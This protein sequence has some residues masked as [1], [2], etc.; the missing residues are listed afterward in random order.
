MMH[1]K[2]EQPATVLHLLLVVLLAAALYAVLH[3]VGISASITLPLVAVFA[4]VTT[5][6]ILCLS[7]LHGLAEHKKR[8]KPD[9]GSVIL[10]NNAQQH[11]LLL[12]E[13][14]EKPLVIAEA[15][16]ED[17]P[18]TLE[19]VLLP[20]QAPDAP[21]VPE[22]ISNFEEDEDSVMRGEDVAVS[23]L[24]INGNGKYG[25]RKTVTPI[26]CIPDILEE[27]AKYG[28]SI[29][30]ILRRNVN[31]LRFIETAV[32]EVSINRS[33]EI[34]LNIVE[35]RR[36]IAAFDDR[37]KTLKRLTSNHSSPDLLKARSLIGKPL[38]LADDAMHS[39][40]A[41]D[42]PESLMPEQWEG[43]L[44]QLLGKCEYALG[45]IPSKKT[46]NL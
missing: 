32:N 9:Q 37:L 20:E 16:R 30:T 6:A 42:I 7:R 41:S 22:F 19:Q 26:I 36:I 38:T 43:E 12:P 15:P 29:H 45:Q 27:I 3:G 25:T 35:A 13:R 23:P 31:R 4:I 2:T 40:I 39:L 34:S 46:Q 21:P 1:V 33:A 17:D 28:K 24:P 11:A 18:P 8:S 10:L 44:E 14:E 5:F